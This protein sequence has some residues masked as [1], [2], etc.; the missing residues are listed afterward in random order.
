MPAELPDIMFQCA[1]LQQIF[2]IGNNGYV[3]FYFFQRIINLRHIIFNQCGKT[4]H[5]QLAG[6]QRVFQLFRFFSNLFFRTVQFLF[7][8]GLDIGLFPHRMMETPA[9]RTWLSF[10]Q[11]LTKQQH[12]CRQQSVQTLGFLLY[13]FQPLFLR[14]T[15][16]LYFIQQLTVR[17]ALR[18]CHFQIGKQAG[19][20]FN[21]RNQL[22][23]SSISF[24]PG[25]QG[26]LLLHQQTYILLCLTNGLTQI[27][28]S[29]QCQSRFFLTFRQ[30]LSIFHQLH[31]Q[32][33]G[34]IQLRFLLR[35]I[36][37]KFRQFFL[38]G[39]PLHVRGSL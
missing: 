38:S 22:G 19:N 17:Y 4:G 6:I 36:G 35:Q 16:F 29:L 23:I 14:F 28:F 39:F 12:L 18:P 30:L 7:L 27:I 24:K 8:Q 26:G 21:G 15:R 31:I 20:Q 1:L 34:F 3:C 33:S 2:P 37:L 32:C 25:L 9:N 10:L 13:R 11:L 5:L